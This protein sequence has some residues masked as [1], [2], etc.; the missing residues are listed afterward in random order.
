ML[1]ENYLA[2]LQTGQYLRLSREADPVGWQEH[3]DFQQEPIIPR[4]RVIGAQLKFRYGHMSGK[5][6]DTVMGEA[7]CV[8]AITQARSKIIDYVPVA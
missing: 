8:H 2:K 1:V 3:D 5:H 4:G 6:D 7:M